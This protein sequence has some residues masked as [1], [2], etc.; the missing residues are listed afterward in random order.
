MEYLLPAVGEAAPEGRGQEL[1]EGPCADEQATLASVHAH[2]LE[3]HA[4][5]REQRAKRRVEEEVERL[6]GQQFGVYGARSAH[7]LQHVTAPAHFVR[8]VLRRRVP[9]T[10]TRSVSLATA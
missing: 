3:I 8:C 10:R 7:E 6:H 5:Q 2:L 4:H 9:A 1:D